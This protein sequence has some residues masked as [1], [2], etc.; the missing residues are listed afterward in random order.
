MQT[1]CIYCGSSSRARG[2]YFDAA[3][4]LARLL[5]QRNITIVYG[6][7]HVGLMGA[8]ADA[9]LEAG[10]GVIGVIPRALVAKEVA[11]TGLT[12]LRIVETMQQRK[13]L[14]SELA[15]GFIAL[16][17]GF[18][19]LDELFETLTEIQLGFHAKP[20]A[21]LN[22]EGYFDPLIALCDRAVADGFLHPAHRDMVL[23]G[24]DPA[25]LLGRM[26]S[27]RDP[28]A[29]KWRAPRS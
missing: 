14:M 18:G 21:L 23:A 5:A 16:P 17:G 15:D 27:F 13:T 19:T 4:N 8:V 10:G 26:D 22:V 28:A 20:C 29:G 1:V 7:A 6:G 11:H 24:S 12:D 3:R 2:V 25:S 9:A